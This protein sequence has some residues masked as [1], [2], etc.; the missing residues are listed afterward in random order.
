MPGERLKAVLR[1][2]R[3]RRRA[4]SRR[5]LSKFL[6]KFHGSTAYHRKYAIAALAR[7]AGEPVSPPKRRR[8][9]STCFCQRGGKALLV[10]FA[11]AP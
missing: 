7:P 11:P 2:Y 10:L 1:M 4:A 9:H 3:E 8:G 6:D 5:E